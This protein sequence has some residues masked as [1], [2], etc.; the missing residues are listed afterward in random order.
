MMKTKPGGDKSLE[1][2]IFRKMSDQGIVGLSIATARNGRPY[3]HRGFGFKDFTMGTST[4][5]R[6]LYCVG[7]VTKAFTACAVLKLC[8][9]GKLNLD[10][11]IGM[12]LPIELTAM[13]EPVLIR[14]LLSHS[15]GL[16]ALGYAEATLSALTDFSEHWLPI[17]SPD[18]LM[19]FM[20]GADDWA[21]AKPGER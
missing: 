15:S 3:Y 4:S 5:H 14:H 9:E 16:S 17:S 1:D 8:E 18:D 11:P 12:F 21:M 7:S 10:D 2:Y 6:T 20:N 19:V 13:G